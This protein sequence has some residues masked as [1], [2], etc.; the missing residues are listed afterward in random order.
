[1]V[2]DISALSPVVPGEWEG[3]G[4]RGVPHMMS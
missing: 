3:G 2:E 4:V 1:M